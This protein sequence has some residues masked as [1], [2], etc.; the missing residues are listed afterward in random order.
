[1]NRGLSGYIA[2]PAGPR[3]I[4]P[5]S[6]L[7]KARLALLV[8][9]VQNYITLPEYSGAWTAAGGDDYYYRR[10]HEE[11]LPN[12]L[13]LLAAFR[14]LGCLVLYTRIAS[15]NEN[16]RDVPGLARQVLAAGLRDLHGSP[17]HL[18]AGERA[19]QVD[20][21][22]RPGPQDVVLLKT[23]SGAFCS[24]NTD[25]VLRSNGVDRLVFA[26]GLTDA[27]VSSSVREAYDRGYLCTIAEDACIAPSAEDH[28]AA[29]RSLAKYYGW[30]TG[31]AEILARLGSEG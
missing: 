1:M 3:G 26:G 21:R 27:C 17:Y 9:D 22:L 7:E 15:L 23:G 29:L 14:G 16:L 12:L 24:A 2:D 4:S 13:K 31:T 19:A 10:L 11:V 30:V 5:A 18:L 6:W 20:E 25:N 28:Q 8:I